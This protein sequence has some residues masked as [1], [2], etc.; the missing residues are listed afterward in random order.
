MLA[1]G[2]SWASGLW[3]GEGLRERMVLEALVTVTHT[4]A[5]EIESDCGPLLVSTLA[6]YGTFSDCQPFPEGCVGAC[7]TCQH[8]PGLHSATA[9]ML[10]LLGKL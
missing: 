9:L 7:L 6:S 2:S 8:L 3:L 5:A 10:C 1:V 4:L